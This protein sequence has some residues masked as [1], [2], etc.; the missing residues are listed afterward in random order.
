KPF[1]CPDHL[2]SGR[3]YYTV[4]NSIRFVPNGREAHSGID[5]APGSLAVRLYGEA[6]ESGIHDAMAIEDPA[7]F[8]AVALRQMLLARGLTVTG[9]ARPAHRLSTDTREF[10]A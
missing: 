7:A 5:R 8:A 9:A 3:A 2:E 1:A 10:R 4:E 6:N